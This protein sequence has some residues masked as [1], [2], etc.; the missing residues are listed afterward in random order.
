MS[1]VEKVARAMWA[2]RCEVLAE[3]GW[4]RMSLWEH[5]SDTLRD[6]FRAEAR[7]A[8]E[9]IAQAEPDAW[10]YRYDGGKW[11]VQKNKPSWHKG[12]MVDVT[13]EPLFSL[14]AALSN[15]REKDNG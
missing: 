10:R 7:A 5:V 1:M 11:T 6:D 2:R 4:P 14:D 3:A 12:F 13:L 9:A 8:I 15:T